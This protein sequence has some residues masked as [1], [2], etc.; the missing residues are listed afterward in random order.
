MET[1][2]SLPEVD[3]GSFEDQYDDLYMFIPGDNAEISSQEPVMDDRPPLPPP[4]PIVATL[5]LD[6]LPFT[7]QGKFKVKKRTL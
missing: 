4:R 1:K 7:L 6:K 3:S 5:Q 2:H